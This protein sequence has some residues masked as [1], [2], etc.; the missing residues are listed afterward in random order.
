MNHRTIGTQAGSGSWFPIAYATYFFQIAGVTKAF[1]FS[2]MNTCLGFFG[3]NCGMFA[4][5]HLVGRRFILIFGSLTTGCCF[6]GMAV[7]Q[8]VSPGSQATGRALVAFLAIWQ[9]F[10][11]GQYN[12][13]LRPKIFES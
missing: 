1:E 5:R 13:Q 9:V 10:Y 3:I 2:I 6:L 8:S 7:A 11:N 12:S 4:I